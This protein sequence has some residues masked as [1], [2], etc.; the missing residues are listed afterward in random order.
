[1]GW[2]MWLKAATSR[3]SRVRLG[4]LIPG[5]TYIFRIKAENPYGVSE[6]SAQSDPV[7]LPAKR[8]LQQQ[9]YKTKKQ[10]KTNQ[11]KVCSVTNRLG[12]LI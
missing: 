6:P 12:S 2:D 11:F 4:D 3:Q 5:S 9:P 8:Y 10:N 1:M 7:R